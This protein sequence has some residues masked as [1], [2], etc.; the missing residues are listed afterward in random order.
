[1]ETV[2]DQVTVVGAGY[3]GIVTAVG[4]ADLGLHVRLVEIRADRVDA[5]INGQSPIHE[6][7][8]QTRLDQVLASG[9]LT[10]DR[11]VGDNLGMVLVCVGTPIGDDG[12]S[13]LS[14]LRSAL[15]S[16]SDKLR[17][18]ATLVIRS[19]LPIG[20]TRR[21]VEWTQLGSAR[22][23]TNPE[24][25]RQGSA[26]ADFARPS[27]IVV[28]RFP[29]ADEAG[30]ARVIALFRGIEAPRLVVDVTAAE[31]IKNGS[32]A[33]LALKLSFANE[34]AA[35]CE[36][37][38]ADVDEVLDGIKADPRIGGSYMRPSFGFGGSCLP[39]ELLTLAV[40]GRDSGLPMHVTTAAS[41]A[42]HA[43]QAR[44]AQRIA[45][46]LGGISGRTIGL[47]GLAY[48]A[49]T[50]DVRESPA[51]RL[52]SALMAGGATV[53]AFDPAAGANA[54][55]EVP[56]LVVVDQ[57]R[58]VF[59]GADGVVV[60]TEWPQFRNVPWV[61]VKASMNRPLLFD[62]RRILDADELR[63]V[64]YEVVVLGDGRS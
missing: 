8:L 57:A 60:G 61:D 31:I 62:G 45:S 42:N 48:K 15:T 3:V 43:Q 59:E 22:T 4:L 47:L 10:V 52:A 40:A 21:A 9:R 54:K 56:G 35:L 26:V 46:R 64:G 39:K 20:G 13:D 37:A 33:F 25:L 53:Q 55:Q 19:T 24:F 6:P 16:L 50:D 30:L 5:L 51:L 28:G 1:M 27:R 23:F 11:L 63:A 14:Q 38:G 41:E 2:G 18:D 32:N 44:F 17:R 7:G 36:E 58:G 49:D 34:V 29:E 12:R